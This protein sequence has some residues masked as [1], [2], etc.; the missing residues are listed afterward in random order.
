MDIEDMWD[1]EED[2]KRFNVPKFG[3]RDVTRRAAVPTNTLQVKN[4]TITVNLK[5]DSG[6]ASTETH[7][8][9][10]DQWGLIVAI[11]N[12]ATE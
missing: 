11:M 3:T 4:A 6:Y 9:S 8:V 1:D 7:R 2:M 10:P 5:A 12:E